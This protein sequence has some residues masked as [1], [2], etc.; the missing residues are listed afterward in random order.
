MLI[1]EDDFVVTDVD[2]TDRQVRRQ[3]FRSAGIRNRP[4]IER[5]FLD[6]AGQART[7]TMKPPGL[8]GKQ[9][10]LRWTPLGASMTVGLSGRIARP[11]RGRR[12]P[13]DP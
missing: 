11:P 12:A 6:I 4:G 13:G 2:R 7:S 9:T 5:V 3:A 1:V 10:R 8:C